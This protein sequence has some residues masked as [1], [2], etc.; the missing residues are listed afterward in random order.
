MEHP[1]PLCTGDEKPEAMPLWLEPTTTRCDISMLGLAFLVI[2]RHW[3]VGSATHDQNPFPILQG[4]IQQ[5]QR[6]DAWVYS[7]L[8]GFA[9]KYGDLLLG[10]FFTCRTGSNFA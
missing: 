10:D 7:L 5:C 8:N 3:L 1:T 4:L 6:L 9:M 2:L